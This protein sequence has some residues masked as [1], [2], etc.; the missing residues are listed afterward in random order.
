MKKILLITCGIFLISGNGFAGECDSYTKQPVN[1]KVY[2]EWQYGIDKGTDTENIQFVLVKGTIKKDDCGISQ[3]R[4]FRGHAEFR[5]LRGE[6]NISS[7]SLGKFTH[8]TGIMMILPEGKQEINLQDFNSDG[9]L[10]FPFRVDYGASGG[11]Y[12]IFTVEQNGKVS[13]LPIDNAF[14]LLPDV[15]FNRPLSTKKIDKYKDYMRVHNARLTS[16]NQVRGIDETVNT[17]Y[18]WN[19]KA[20]VKVSTSTV[21]E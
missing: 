7:Y 2:A 18:R 8:Y 16:L 14:H 15:D 13:E 6:K 3:E 10:D 4:A 20:F 1:E 12:R 9:R 5:V 17:Y 19:G 21:F 11:Y